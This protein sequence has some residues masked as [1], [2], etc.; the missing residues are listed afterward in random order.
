MLKVMGDRAVNPFLADVDKIKV[1]KVRLSVHARLLSQMPVC[2][3]LF[4]S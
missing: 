1:D 3:V 2:G 4:M